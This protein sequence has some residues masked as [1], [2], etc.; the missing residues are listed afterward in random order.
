MYKTGGRNTTRTGTCPAEDRCQYSP[1]PPSWDSEALDLPD[2]QEVVHSF[3][4]GWEID[5]EAT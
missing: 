3:K 1:G 4:T 5:T 2:L